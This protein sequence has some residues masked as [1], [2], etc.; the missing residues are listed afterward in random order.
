MRVACYVDGFNLYHAIDDL[1][2]PHL[3][4]VDLWALA[5]FICRADEDL[6]KVAYFS[7]YATWPPAPC[8]RHRQ[9]VAALKHHGVECHIARFN[10]SSAKQ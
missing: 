3:K 10:S 2:Q 9:Y 6:I 5:K 8:A 1:A 7:A 4:W